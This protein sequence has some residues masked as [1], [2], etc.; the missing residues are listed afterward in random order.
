MTATGSSIFR[1][2]VAVN[3]KAQSH[4]TYRDVAQLAACLSSMPGPRGSLPSIA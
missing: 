1:N 2:V 4:K 3:R